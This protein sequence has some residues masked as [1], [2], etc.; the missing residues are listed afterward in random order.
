MGYDID[1]P[2]CP[3]Y[4]PFF[5]Y[6][7]VAIGV[8]LSCMGG[9][10]GTAKCGVGLS[11]AAL[12]NKGAIVRGL[13]APIMSGV[14]GIYG[15]VYSLVILSSISNVG[16]S[17]PK[18]FSHLAGGISVGFGGLAAGVTIGCAG[19]KGLPMFAK[20]PALFVGLTLIL[21]FGE[22]LAIYGMV[23]SFILNAKTFPCHPLPEE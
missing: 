10:I 1:D 3:A 18:A 8:V 15:L 4:S 14:I 13:I 21:V 5:G 23:V 16:Y 17:L 7:G 2:L 20:Q 11:S 6:F 9:A 19:Q 12:I 22:V